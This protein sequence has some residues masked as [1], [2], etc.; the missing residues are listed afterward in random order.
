MEGINLKTQYYQKS[1]PRRVMFFQEIP[2]MEKF[3]KLPAN[4]P[5]GIAISINQDS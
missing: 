2:T 5:Q 4:D 1:V 3:P